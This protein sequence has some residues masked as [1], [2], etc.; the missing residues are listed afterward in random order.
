[1]PLCLRPAGMH[2]VDTCA[3]LRLGVVEAREMSNQ[4]VKVR[5]EALAA[6]MTCPICKKLLEEATTIS[7]CLHTFCR[8][9]I[10]ERI[11]DEEVDC[12]PVCN[13]DLGCTP[14]EK[15]R[16]DHNLQDVRAKIFPLKRRKVTAQEVMPSVSVP[17]R[18]K[19]RS[20]SSLVVS[21]PRVLTQTGLTGRRTKAV[22][23]RAVA[24]RG[25]CFSVDE[26][27]KKD[28]DTVEE[29]PQRSSSTETL[30]KTGQNRRQN[31]VSAEPSN[32]ISNKDS[33]NGAEQWPVKS[34]VWKPLNCLVEA[35]NRT[36]TCNFTK[37]GGSAIKEEKID[38]LDDEVHVHKSKIRAHL[39]KQ[40]V[41]DDKND[42]IPTP[43]GL[44]KARRMN[45]TRRKKATTNR[46]LS[47]Q[48]MLDAA[49]VKNMRRISPIWL[50]LVPSDDQEGDASLPRI[51]PC[52]LRIKDGDM[53]VS[54]I[55]KYLAKRLNLTNEAEVEITCRGQPV[56]P[57]MPLRDLVDMWVRTSTAPQR[58]A[59]TVG[60]S[61][62]DFVM[63]LAYARKSILP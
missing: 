58:V 50:S 15:L 5:R 6:C 41:E 17:V 30:N 4:V 21:T 24:L 57:T 59:V 43:S 63:V 54:F 11:N 22:A 45:G 10:Y 18:R 8:K 61:A 38:D 14:A 42:A 20:L 3:N 31:S 1:M 44:T 36:K 23:R 33:D 40:K 60:S 53:L 26:P 34:D 27:V 47:S 13:I 29:H 49:G 32:H 62:K 2:L 9:C 46:E 39:H 35:A 37:Q 52:Y 28:H 25:S 55:Q 51:S 19:E 7:E 56:V 16:P 12:C 48:T